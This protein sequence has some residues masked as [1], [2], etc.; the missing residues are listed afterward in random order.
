MLRLA[1]NTTLHDDIFKVIVLVITIQTNHATS[2][3]DWIGV[4]CALKDVLHAFV[5]GQKSERTDSWRAESHHEDRVWVSSG[6][7][8]N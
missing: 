7:L 3:V 2:L 6:P 1:V 8:L 5:I 4:G